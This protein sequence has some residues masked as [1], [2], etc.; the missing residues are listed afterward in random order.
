M[1]GRDVNVCEQQTSNPGERSSI[2]PRSGAGITGPDVPPLPRPLSGHRGPSSDAV[3]RPG[4]SGGE[5]AAA[6][7]DVSAMHDG[8]YQHRLTLTGFA[9]VPRPHRS[10]APG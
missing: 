8:F 3:N 6:S 5:G 10:A 1:C 2:P 7:S 9:G 4:C